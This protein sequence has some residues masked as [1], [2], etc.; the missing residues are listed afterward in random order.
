MR[1][2]EKLGCWRRPSRRSGLRVEE[3]A[4]KAATAVYDDSP[5]VA[6]E[7]VSETREATFDDVSLRWM[8]CRSGR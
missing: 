6:K 7:Y 4:S 5:I 1:L 8:S 3:E 2:L